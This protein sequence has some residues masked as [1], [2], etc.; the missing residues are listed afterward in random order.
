MKKIKYF[1]IGFLLAWSAPAHAEDE[2]QFTDLKKGEVA[3]FDGKLMN[4]PAVSKLVVEDRFKVQQCDIQINH[5]VNK[6]KLEEEYK[7]QILYAKCESADQRLTDMI[8]VRDDHIKEL[9]KH[10]APSNKHWWTVGGFVV[11][12]GVSV[13]I[14][15]AIAPGLR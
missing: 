9:Q 13:G 3:P 7:Y 1:I 8:Q 4:L 11:G 14:M 6:V 15:Y 5:E 2:P 10:I 12:A